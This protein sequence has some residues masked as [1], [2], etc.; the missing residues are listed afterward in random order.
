L[1]DSGCQNTVISP[2]VIE[3]HHLQLILKDRPLRAIN[4]DGS[5][6]KIGLV[7]HEVNICFQWANQEESDPWMHVKAHV[8]EIGNDDL[9]LGYDFLDK[10][11]P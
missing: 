5:P 10:Y 9:V 4:I 11:N 3:K 7:T 1:L 6:N 2:Q 8:A